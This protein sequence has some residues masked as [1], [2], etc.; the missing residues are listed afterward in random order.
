MGKL[1]SNQGDGN[2][3]HALPVKENK[4]LFGLQ[5]IILL[6]L[7]SMKDLLITIL[8]Q[9]GKEQHYCGAKK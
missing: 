1:E 5:Q 8:Q 9:L 4:N 2:L 6:S 3:F 7:I